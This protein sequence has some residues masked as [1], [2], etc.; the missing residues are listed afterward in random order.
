MTRNTSWNKQGAFCHI[1]VSRSRSMIVQSLRKTAKCHL[2]Q[3]CTCIY[4]PSVSYIRVLPLGLNRLTA[5]RSRMRFRFRHN[6]THRVNKETIMIIFTRRCSMTLSFKCFF[7]TYLTNF[8]YPLLYSFMI[9]NIWNAPPYLPQSAAHH[10]GW[11]NLIWNVLIL[12]CWSDIYIFK[13]F[14]SLLTQRVWKKRYAPFVIAIDLR[15]N[16]W[17]VFTYILER[18]STYLYK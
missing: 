12:P 13:S 14:L 1:P 7:G 8:D 10:A 11:D 4:V 2:H 17:L 5:E 9:F 3:R 16:P 18:K 6:L 15:S